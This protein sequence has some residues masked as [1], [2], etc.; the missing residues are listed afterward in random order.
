MHN[1]CSAKHVYHK[2]DVTTFIIN[3]KASEAHKLF[4]NMH[5]RHI[6][7]NNQNN[8]YIQLIRNDINV[9]NDTTKINKYNQ[10]IEFISEYRGYAIYIYIYIYIHI[11]MR[12]KKILRIRNNVVMLIYLKIPRE[13]PRDQ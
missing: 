1:I 5:N 3:N 4:D 10:T 7:K 2:S 11:L 9:E 12:Y 8:A 13:S 6:S